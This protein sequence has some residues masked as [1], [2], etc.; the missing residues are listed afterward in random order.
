[1]RDDHAAV[2][3][4]GR[5]GRQR[6][7]DVFIR[8]SVEAVALHAGVTNFLRQRHEFRH[9]RLAAMEAGVEAGHLRHAGQLVPHGFDRGQVVGLMERRQRHQRAKVLQ[10][11]RRDDAG[12]GVLGAAMHDAM[13]DAQHARAG[14]AF[15]EPSGEHAERRA[16]IANRCIQRVVGQLRTRVVLGRETRRCSDPVDLAARL[17]TPGLLAGP[18]IHAELQARRTGIEDE[19]VVVHG[20]SRRLARRL[21]ARMRRHHRHG[22]TGDARPDAVGPAGENHRAP[23]RPAPGRR[24]R[25]WPGS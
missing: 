19:C 2:G 5:D 1:M 18:A 22:A 23:W 9:G 15:A 3:D 13:A 17:Q 4:L 7:R 25:R 12:T 6:R 16:P 10:D 8:E 21:P 24:C 20:P 11:F 14:V